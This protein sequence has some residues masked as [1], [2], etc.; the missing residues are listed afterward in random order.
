M[1]F[2]R[3][4]HLA[5]LLCL[6]HSG[7]A[8]F[9]SDQISNQIEE[10]QNQRPRTILY[11]ISGTS[12][13]L[14]RDE[15]F[16]DVYQG[17]ASTNQKNNTM[18]Q[19]INQ[20]QQNQH[21]NYLGK[22]FGEGDEA[23]TTLQNQRNER[24]FATKKTPQKKQPQQ[25]NS[26]DLEADSLSIFGKS[27]VYNPNDKKTQKPINTQ[28]T[29]DAIIV[30]QNNAVATTDNGSVIRADKITVNSSNKT[31][32]FK[33]NINADII[34][35]DPAAAGTI[36]LKSD[37]MIA[38]NSLDSMFLQNALIS[39]TSGLGTAYI[40]GD[41]IEKDKNKFIISNSVISSCE[42]K[43]CE[44]NILPWSF[45]ASTTTFDNEKKTAEMQNFRF[46]LYNVP[47]FYLPFVKANL[48]NN[49]RYIEEQKVIALRNQ[50]G[51]GLT[52]YPI[53]KE[54]TYG[55]KIL[56]HF[57]LYNGFSFFNAIPIKQLQTNN[58]TNNLAIYRQNNFGI[59]AKKR[60]E[61][62][63]F[64]L[65]SR[66]SKDYIPNVPTQ[67]VLN[68]NKENRYYVQFNGNNELAPKQNSIARI[69]YEFSKVSD[70]YFVA[71]YDGMF[72]P[73]YSTNIKYQKHNT[74][75]K[76]FFNINAQQFQN[77]SLALSGSV[78]E[79]R[80]LPQVLFNKT[81]TKKDAPLLDE[82]SYINYSSDN[83][84]I[85]NK[86][87]MISTRLSNSLEYSRKTAIMGY[88]LANV[89]VR[90]VSNV[91]GYQSMQNY[92]SVLLTETNKKYGGNSQNQISYLDFNFS[93]ASPLKKRTKFAT[94]GIEPKLA[95]NYNPSDSNKENILN[96]DSSTGY[97]N[98][99]N[100]FSN[101]SVAGFDK[102]EDGLRAT[103]GV[104]LSSVFNKYNKSGA[105]GVFFTLAQRYNNYNKGTV[106][107]MSYLSNGFNGYS[108]DLKIKYSI[109]TLDSQNVTK[110]AS[111]FN[112]KFLLNRAAVNFKYLNVS[113][114]SYT[115][116]QD[117]FSLSPINGDIRSTFYIIAFKPIK[118]Y[119]IEQMVAR[120]SIVNS[121]GNYSTTT[122]LSINYKSDC[123]IYSLGLQTTTATQTQSQQAQQFIFTFQLML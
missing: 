27:L 113:A 8:A 9:A 28:K 96:Q 81:F 97:L 72:D 119:F 48:S 83:L 61:T 1:F 59:N 52:L 85:L 6:L 99:S 2:W 93:A 56:P 101:N 62:S 32:E 53:L 13:S 34:S 23:S 108:T 78:Q 40:K 107:Q 55:Y 88:K 95:V 19:T 66:F 80:I 122:R 121:P 67:Q 22:G 38:F 18:R 39:Y 86:Q 92:E 26:I 114:G 116:S 41:F 103:Y 10:E 47:V 76:S 79:P 57:E 37:E 49:R 54:K 98:P 91:Y 5:L 33:G 104:T 35:D 16:E 118:S 60:T 21:L 105:D 3:S 15:P 87:G 82:N 43:R 64:K 20:V 68:T 120:N 102:T 123:L 63:N 109:F 46:K 73:Y 17:G 51:I 24:E 29:N 4:L 42:T 74:A 11:S 30:A 25:I 106:Q 71:K 14:L 94:L 75:Q 77:I 31:A 110:S 115:M 111:D 12:Q 69:D 117:Y 70:I 112:S 58:T 44:K 7:Q 90:G 45:T 50:S 65:K 36:N 89:G 100:I 84:N